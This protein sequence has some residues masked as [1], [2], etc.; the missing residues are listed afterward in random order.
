MLK[1]IKLI[2]IFLFLTTKVQ[3]SDIKNFQLEGIS[4]YDSALDHFSKQEIENNI[5][6]WYKNKKFTT[7]AIS[8]HP[9]FKKYD[10]LQISFKTNDKR[11]IIVDISGL[12]DKN[13]STCLKELSGIE[14]E[15]DSL[16]TNTK[17]REQTKYTHPVDSSNKSTVTDVFW[18]F[19]NGDLVLAACY[20]WSQIGK[21]KNYKDDF[22]ITISNKEFDKFLSD[23]PY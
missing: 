20:D 8:Y 9:K 23:N 5:Q 13:S 10:E 21:F 4:L 19:K 14:S 11:Y 2:L 1:K 22:R 18:K 6:N 16:F 3:A 17:K 15:L 7:S 12:V